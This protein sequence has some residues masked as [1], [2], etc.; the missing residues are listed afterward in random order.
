[1]ISGCA[2]RN[3]RRS[4][5]SRNGKNGGGMRLQ[6]VR[7]EIPTYAGACAPAH[8][9]TR[10]HAR[11]GSTRCTRRSRRS[12]QRRGLRGFA[13]VAVGVARDRAAV[14]RAIS[15]LLTW[16]RKMKSRSKSARRRLPTPRH[17]LCALRRA[18]SGETA[19]PTSSTPGGAGPADAAAA[20]APAR[21]RLVRWPD[22]D[23]P[24]VERS[25]RSRG[26]IRDG[27]DS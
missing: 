24:P 13:P 8:P 15:C 16:K 9:R 27:W 3:C 23:L 21:E 26:R 25:T 6:R 11:A 4:D 17:L 1:M 12:R 2:T 10:G 22:H 14:A 18:W 20:A 7:R 19:A 5:G